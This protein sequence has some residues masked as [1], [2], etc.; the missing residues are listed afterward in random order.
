MTKHYENWL[1]LG[2]VRSGTMA[3]VNSLFYYKPL[4]LRRSQRPGLEPRRLEPREIIHAHNPDWL[5]HVTK[6]TGVVICVRNPLASALSWS[7]LPKFGLVDQQPI[8]HFHRK[9]AAKVQE[10]SENIQPFYLPLEQVCRAVEQAENFYARILQCEHLGQH[11]I[12]IYE[13]WCDDPGRILTQ[14]GIRP[15]PI[16]HLLKSPGTPKQWI[17]NFDE[18]IAYG[19]TLNINNF[20]QVCQLTQ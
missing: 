17:E 16:P 7:I 1:V 13:S 9:D 19:K 12:I 14:L 5:D 11:R 6:D 8:F 10:I 15:Y 2:P 4:Q 3:V 18:V 20:L